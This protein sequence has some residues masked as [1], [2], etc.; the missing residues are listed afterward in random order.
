M[1]GFEREA[2][3]EKAGGNTVEIEN[4]L[5]ESQIRGYDAW[6]EFLLSSMEDVD[7]V[8]VRSSDFLAYFSILERNRERVPWGGKIDGFLFE[9]YVLPHRVSQEPLESFTTLYGDTLYDLVKDAKDM[10]EAVIRINEWTFTKMKYEPTARWDQNATTTILRGFG[11]C[12][13]MAILC[14]KAMRAVCIPARKVYTPW[15]PFTNSN[16]AWVEVWIDGK[17]HFL[18]GAEPTDLEHAWFNF[19][20]K[21]SAMVVGVVYGDIPPGNEVIYKKQKGYTIINSTPNYADVTELHIRVLQ[22]EVPRESVSVALCV[23]NYS[24]LP[25]VGIKKTDGTGCASF[26]AGRTDLFVF[27][28]VDS[29]IDYTVWK[30]TEEDC[31][32]IILNVT[33]KVLPDTSFWM[34]TKRIEKQEVKPTYQPNRDSLKLLQSLHFARIQMVDSTLASILPEEERKRV[35]IFYHAKGRAPAL[36]DFYRRL[37]DSLK[38]TFLAYGDALHPKDLVSIDTAGLLEE[39]LAVRRSRAWC[40]QEAP[41]SLINRYL[42]SGRILFEHIGLWRNAVQNDFATFREKRVGGTAQKVFY[43]V[44]QHVEKVDKRGYFGPMKNPLDVQATMRGTDGERYIFAAAVLRSL[45][46]PAR[47]K[48]SYDAM[49]FWS[50][51]WSELRFDERDEDM[52]E[53]WVALTF[54]DAAGAVAAPYRYYYDYSITR[55]EEYPKRLDPPVD[56]TGGT[57]VI[58]LDDEPCSVITG[59][60]NGYGDTHVRI[61]AFRPSRDTLN[62]LVRTGIPDDIR[63]EDLMVREYRGLD[64]HP[65]GMENALIEEGDVLVMVFDL[66]TEAS[67]STL[68]AARDALNAFKGRL[69]LF[70]NTPDQQQGESFIRSLGIERGTVTSV[71]KQVYRK[72]WRMKDLPAVLYVRNGECVFWTEGLFLHL[73]RL[74]ED[75]G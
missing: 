7:L 32:T 40:S 50:G 64:L 68:L 66:E 15:W 71:E 6:A 27:A 30:P 51:Y 47:V 53:R 56:T 4:L 31:D 52:P 41:D 9:H 39:L 42:I 26:T 37:P 62:L 17:W 29:F 11:R 10:R 59:W 44:E 14:I 22:N 18:G 23:Y 55:F 61:K 8:N 12:E 49:E 63:P 74:L 25:P 70:V 34:H 65:I 48:W 45:G 60:R 36:L 13:E 67:K 5:D 54:E 2:I 72:T 69:L 19:P 21:R 16:H 3:L 75:L 58:T 73:S 35:M 24:S 33:V 46:I 38:E 43:W 28:S 57:A 1:H 20:A